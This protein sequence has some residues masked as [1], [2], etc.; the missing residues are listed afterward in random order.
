MRVPA[1]SDAP[2]RSLLLVP[3]VA[4]AVATG[5]SGAGPLH[6]PYCT[7]G[8]SYEAGECRPGRHVPRCDAT[9][10]TRPRIPPPVQDPFTMVIASD[11]QM[12]WGSD[13]GCT[14]TPENCVLAYGRQTNLWFAQAM[15]TIE[16]LGTWPAAVANSG[17]L[18]VLAPVGVIVNG[19]LTAF[20]HGWQLNRYREYY[21]PAYELADPDVMQ[22]PVY[23]G[24]GNH[25]YANNVGDCFG[26]EI[27]DW[28]V[29]G[30]NSCAAH[31]A[32][33]VRSMVG[34]GTVAN[35]L[36][37]N[38]HSFDPNSLAYSWDY[39]GWHFVQLHNYPTYEVPAIGVTS[40]IGWL[41]Q[42]L[43]D[44][45][46]AEKRIIINLHDHQQH[47]SMN[48]PGFQAAIASANVAAVFAGHL[49]S[50]DGRISQVPGTSIPV[51]LSG[52][53]E[54]NRLLLVE[55]AETYF[56]VATLD[57]AGGAPS[58][59]TTVVSADLDSY[60][61]STPASIDEDL[62]GVT[63]GVD[64]CSKDA[65]PSQLDS[66]GG[67]IGDACDN[68]AAVTNPDQQDT[69]SDLVGDACDLCP[70]L[71]NPTQE[72]GDAD[73]IGDPCDNCPAVPNT[74]QED[75]DGDGLG[76]VC[77]PI[78]EPSGACGASPRGSCDAST[79]A[80]LLIKDRSDDVK[81]I[82]KLKVKGATPRDGAAF[83]DPTDDAWTTMCLYYDDQLEAAYPIGPHRYRW[84]ALSKGAG[85]K[86]SASHGPGAG[87]AKV[88]AKAGKFGEPKE[89]TV[90][91]KGLGENLPEAQVPVPG[92]VTS[93]RVQVIH[94][95]VPTCLEASFTAPFKKNL[96][97]GAGTVRLLKALQ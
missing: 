57:T 12:P 55:F 33:Y 20:W 36:P 97:N 88:K 45:T 44:A 71:A 46:A 50:L 66:D 94:D 95:T 30:N 28:S 9:S 8:F 11:T 80:L 54:Y 89:P 83:G 47:W 68:C 76:D 81:D 48:D 60:A 69:D 77:D 14:D 91:L 6:Q 58:F 85:F 96:A 41:A 56:T 21:D 61:V 34:C 32:R 25:D 2:L 35:F 39:R 86:Y 63:G 90:V 29:F 19:D 49:H 52:A 13:P 72:D 22:L 93:I 75:A 92:T 65:N 87:I 84:S 31:A 27:A 82:I 43:A 38:V 4:L 70:H 5:A 1:A 73:A 16:S 51:F 10:F 53:A 67:G 42:D 59:V 17:S 23:P 24:L 40:S 15:A 74:G 78:P 37:S 3:L 7:T 62:D 64:N 26:V 18:P 79:K